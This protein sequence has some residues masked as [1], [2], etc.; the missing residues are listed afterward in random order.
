[1]SRRRS[2]TRKETPV[3]ND[4]EVQEILAAFTASPDGEVPIS[5]LPVDVDEPPRMKTATK[6][7]SAAASRGTSS[8]RGAPSMRG[9]PSMRGAASRGRGASRGGATSG[10]AA[11]MA[12]APNG[13]GNGRVPS[14]SGQL[15]SRAATMSGVGSRVTRR[16]PTAPRTAREAME[17]EVPM[18]GEGMEERMM[19]G[20]LNGEMD[21]DEFAPPHGTSAKIV[22][23]TTMSP[24]SRV[25]RPS[26]AAEIVHSRSAMPRQQTMMRAEK[27]VRDNIR[28]LG[29]KVQLEFSVEGKTLALL[30]L[31]PLG[32]RVLIKFK[33]GTWIPTEGDFV[34]V[35]ATEEHFV[36][37]GTRE[38]YREVLE[39]AETAYG[40][41]ADRGLCF[42]S[43]RG[44][45]ERCWEFLEAEALPEEIDPG[46][47]GS[48]PISVVRYDQLRDSRLDENTVFDII[49]RTENNGDLRKL[50]RGLGEFTILTNLLKLTGIDDLLR[51]RSQPFTLLAPN[52]AAFNKIDPGT[53]RALM[54]KKNNTK[55][56]NILTYHLYEGAQ[57]AQ[58]VGETPT[59]QGEP[60]EWD[61]IN[62]EQVKAGKAD[63]L[64]VNIEASNGYIHVLDTVL[65]PKRFVDIPI[66]RQI[67]Q[68]VDYESIDNTTSTLRAAA[69]PQIESQN[70]D[71]RET[72]SDIKSR[73]DELTRIIERTAY[74]DLG[75]DIVRKTETFRSASRAPSRPSD[76]V[77]LGEEISIAN[78]QFD[79]ALAS[80][81]R[82]VSVRGELTR[83]RDH[84]DDILRELNEILTARPE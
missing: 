9:S 50:P 2:P 30:A 55:L 81:Q 39:N 53:L 57:D 18:R 73:V 6:I 41:L 23:D 19:N 34:E 84:L 26:R 31:T 47:T 60:V 44:T 43:K 24:R 35:A 61:K 42:I 38:T 69:F 76:A 14:R 64:A 82:T 78:Q 13:N 56:W 11:R 20:E 71:L 7:R 33:K 54:E 27:M 49:A 67:N 25:T 21:D 72:A 51:N 83:L 4:Q 45:K 29:Y 66:S 59:V 68:S 48:F 5:D 52:D 62:P 12:T 10:V 1:M 36:S 63:V 8:M 65:M 16:A 77:V 58:Q 70:A 32:Q 46:R 28:D 80:Q 79:A 15:A 74:V 37:D 75:Q 40:F 3:S 17:E 22:T